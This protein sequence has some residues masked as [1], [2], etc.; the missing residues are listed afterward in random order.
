VP[1][2]KPLPEFRK[3]PIN[4]VAC[5]VLFR[6]NRKILAPHLGLLW[7]RLKPDYTQCQEAPPLLATIETFGPGE[8]T[9]QEFE[10]DFAPLPRIFFIDGPG[11]RVVQVQRD[12]FHHNWRRIKPEDEYPRFGRVYAAFESYFALFQKF[13]AENE[14]GECAPIQF[15]LTYVDHL[16]QGEGWDKLAD[17][18]RVFPDF[19]W[20]KNP[21]R[22]LANPQ[23][24][25]WNTTFALPEDSGRLHI[26]IRS[27]RRKEDGKAL[28][29]L[30]STVR[31]LGKDAS[32]KGMQEW[33][34][35]A[36]EWMLMGFADITSDEIQRRV[37][38]R[39]K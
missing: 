8:G 29:Y 34:S 28:I 33:F 21:D 12:R 13:L 27:A 17:V 35:V 6:T 10:A 2:N 14:L 7:E 24:I 39:T 18:S 26:S 23:T 22:L 4:E 9:Q 36:H 25:N 30:E 19:G 38:E 3:P 11:N 15:E 1:L 37:W 32:Q 16:F 31:G 5:G 20:R